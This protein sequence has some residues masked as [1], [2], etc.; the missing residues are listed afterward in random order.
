MHTGVHTYVCVMTHWLIRTYIHTYIRTY[1]H[2]L[3]ACIHAYMH[4]CIYAHACMHEYMHTFIHAYMHTC[5]HKYR[6]CIL[7]TGWRRPIRCLKLQVISR[8]RATNCRA[9]LLKMTCK[10]KAFYASVPPCKRRYIYDLHILRTSILHTF[11]YDTCWRIY[12]HSTNSNSIPKHSLNC[13]SI[14]R[15]LLAKSLTK[16]WLFCERHLAI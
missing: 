8:K 10:D 16:I 11:I 2:G 7:D 1:I 14:L 5:T 13:T 12:K 6:R 4:T 3:H 9:L 15:S